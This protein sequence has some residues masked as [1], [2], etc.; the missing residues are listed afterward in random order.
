MNAAKILL[1]VLLLAGAGGA[2]WFLTREEPLPPPVTEPTTPPPLVDPKTEPPTQPAAATA[3]TPPPPTEN[4]RTVVAGADNAAA[5]AEQGV[6][7]RVLLPGGAPGGNIAVFLMESTMN[8]PLGTYLKAKTGVRTPPVA[9]SITA[10]DG[11]FALGVRKAGQTVDLRIISD[12]HP[13]LHHKGVKIRTEDWYDAGNLQLEQGLVVVGRVVLEGS[14]QPI[15]NAQVFLTEA[16]ATHQMLPTP[17]REQGITVLTNAAGAFRFE[18]APRLGL[19]SLAATAPGHARAEKPNL[20]ITAESTNEFKL[21]L[22][23]GLPIA[24]VVTDPKG[25]PISGCTIQASALSAKAPQN[26]TAT[27]GTD[28]RFRFEGMREGEFQLSFVAA[29]YEEHQEKPVPAGKL[30]VSVPL[31]PRAFA[32]LRVLAAN[33]A[34]IKAYKVSLKRFFPNNPLGI[35]NVPEFRDARIT[36]GDYP[37]EF[38][39]DWAVIRGVPN[40]EFVF[41]VED[42]GQHA[43]SLSEPFKVEANGASPEVLCRLTLGGVIEGHV[44]DDAGRPVAGATVTTDMNGAFMAEDGGFFA[45]F[46]QFMPEKHSKSQ[47]KTDG[48]GRFRLTKLAFADYMIR[49][50]HQDFCEGTSVD[51][52]LESEGQRLDIGTIQLMRGA[53][54]EGVTTV[55]GQPMGQVKVTIGPPDAEQPAGVPAVQPNAQ[56]QTPKQMF[57][58]NATSD[59]NGAFR[60]LKRVPPGTY[61]IHAVREAGSDNP[62]AK[63]LQM[64]QSQ[65][66]LLVAPGQDKIIQNFDLPAQ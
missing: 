27:T 42:N 14:D 5:D 3:E 19:I 24:G 23:V 18:N 9:Q 54:V 50:Q 39:G 2:Y 12:T 30:D 51:I 22:A 44:V 65:R 56:A 41:Q 43:K 15:A 37:P 13:E 17:G 52:K 58:V 1:P 6:R 36:P 8:D 35:G 31:E 48:G 32:K 49:V 11:T 47:T 38:G 57:V 63:L 66:P 33:G 29:G 40:G 10:A 7:G 53:L 46:R 45:M 25:K 26:G 4:V 64:K 55:G 21:E 16:N 20:Q 62:F 34:P 61:K 59:G 60:F 28:G